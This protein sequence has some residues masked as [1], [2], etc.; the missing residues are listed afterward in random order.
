MNFSEKPF[1]LKQ[2]WPGSRVEVPA[3]HCPAHG[4]GLQAAVSILEIADA[5]DQQHGGRHHGFAAAIEVGIVKGG[6][7][8]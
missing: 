4:G 8:S 7:A 3:A 6:E 1:S 2:A 5:D